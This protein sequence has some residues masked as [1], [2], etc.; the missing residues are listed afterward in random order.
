MVTSYTLS[1][2]ASA[3]FSKLGAAAGAALK[4]S[5][6]SL[7]IE[8]ELATVGAPDPKGSRIGASPSS[9][10]GSFAAKVPSTLAMSPPSSNVTAAVT[11]S[12]LVS[13]SAVNIGGSSTVS[14]GDRHHDGVPELCVSIISSSSRASVGMPLGSVAMT[15]T[16]SCPHV[17]RLISSISSS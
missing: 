3:G 10:S 13:T 1:L 15:V 11:V 6:A 9:V 2:S 17:H 14:D 12:P 8:C 16:C 7:R 5:L 4:V